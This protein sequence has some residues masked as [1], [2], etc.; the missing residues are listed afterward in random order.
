MSLVPD[1]DKSL[2]L[3]SGRCVADH[4]KAFTFDS[5]ELAELLPGASDLPDETLRGDRSAVPRRGDHPQGCGGQRGV[6]V[7]RTGRGSSMAACP[8]RA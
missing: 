7:T 8:E 3:S 4:P 5:D 6:P 2:C 1:I